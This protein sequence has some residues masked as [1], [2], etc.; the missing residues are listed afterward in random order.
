ML[1]EG[2]E[3]TIEQD[4]KMQQLRE[5]LSKSFES[6]RNT[7]KFLSADAPIEVLCLPKNIENILLESGCLRVY[8]LFDMDFTK[9]KGLGTVRLRDLTARLQQFISM[10]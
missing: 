1:K 8:D 10:F 5:E 2:S 3:L 7:M 6:Y 9:V 4:I